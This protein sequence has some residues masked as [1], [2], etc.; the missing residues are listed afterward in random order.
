MFAE[1][2]GRQIRP[3]TLALPTGNHNRYPHGLR[4]GFLSRVIEKSAAYSIALLE[5]VVDMLIEDKCLTEDKTDAVHW[6]DKGT[7]WMAREFLAT[8]AIHFTKRTWLHWRYRFGVEGEFKTDVDG[9]FAILKARR[10]D[11]AK[12]RVLSSVADVVEAWQEGYAKASMADKCGS[13]F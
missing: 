9:Y 5:R 4:I 11:A 6:A 8:G 1:F 3:T 13:I 2:V 10:D 7:H 12:K